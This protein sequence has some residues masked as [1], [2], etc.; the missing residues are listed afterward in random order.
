MLRET[1]GRYGITLYHPQSFAEAVS[2]RMGLL[3]DAALVINI[4]GNQASL[5]VCPHAP[6]LP[7]GLITR[8]ISC[9]HTGRGVIERLL[10]RGV[11][12]LHLLNI[13]AFAVEHGLPLTPG[14]DPAGWEGSVYVSRSVS[15]FPVAALLAGLVI[16][17]FFLRRRQM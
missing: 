4:G 3:R 11:P 15:R 12:V 6:V 2:A 13:N 10:E 1:A 16:S 9:D 5:G 7:H 14:S 8:P 17:A